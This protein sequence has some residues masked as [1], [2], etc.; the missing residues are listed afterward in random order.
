MFS[1][2]MIPSI[3]KKVFSWQ[4]SIASLRKQR[5]GKMARSG[6]LA[7]DIAVSFGRVLKGFSIDLET[8]MLTPEFRRDL[9]R[10]VKRHKGNIPLLYLDGHVKHGNILETVR[11]RD[12]KS[13]HAF[14]DRAN[15]GCWSDD[16]ALKK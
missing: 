11:K 16:P 1:S 12:T 15:G 8:P 10:V 3:W 14:S 2:I 4:A 7:A 9:V 6:E 5:P 13:M